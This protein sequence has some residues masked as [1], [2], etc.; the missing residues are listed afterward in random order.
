[1]E[2]VAAEVRESPLVQFFFL[3]A[4][5][6]ATFEKVHWNFLGQVSLADITSLSFLG[7]WTIDRLGRPANGRVPRTAAMLLLFL[8]GFLLVNMVGFF[9]LETTQALDQYVK[10]IVKWLI[11][12]GFVIVGVVYL[13]GRS[14]DFY[15]RTLSWF[16]GGIA[17]NAAYGILQL[18]AA[19]AGHNLDSLFVKPLTRGASQIN[20]YGAVNGA[21]VYRPNALT[22]DPN[23]LAIMILLPLLILS[24]IYLRLERDHPKRLRLAVLI[25]F[26]LIAEL[27]TLSRSGAL[28]VVVGAIVLMIPY[29]RLLF[30]RLAILPLALVAIPVLYAIYR[31]RHFFSVVVSSRLSHGSGSSTHLAVYSFIPKILHSHPLFGLGFN[32]FSVYYQF[33]TGKTNWGP[34]SYYV[35]LIVEGGLVGTALFAAFLWYL[36]WKLGA[37][38]RVGKA[39]AAA[40][41]PL[42]ARVRPLAWGMTA[43]LL[44]TMAANIFYLT[45]SFFYF[46]VFAMLVLVNPSVF[47]RGADELTRVDRSFQ[48][49]ARAKPGRAEV[50]TAAGGASGRA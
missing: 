36:F 40:R 28:G 9:N 17:V 38:R 39:L 34:H 25:A 13:L 26:L 11:H 45:M 2:P 49:D 6:C 16:L 30:S 23:H 27:A 48:T 41:D 47:S 5:F 1:V 12:F 32:N 4:V 22:L 24:P 37:A 43:A 21:N 44:G 3:A 46:Y 15:W 10:G 42:A 50:G 20:I 29:R 7:V 19:Q 35:M 8:A 14:R 18:L 33:V 31:R